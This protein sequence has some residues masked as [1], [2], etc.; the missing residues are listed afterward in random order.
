MELS[1]QERKE[2]KR[3]TD[4]ATKTRKFNTWGGIFAIVFSILFIAMGVY[5]F[6]ELLPKFNMVTTSGYDQ[7]QILTLWAYTFILLGFSTFLTGFMMLQYCKDIYFLYALLK[8]AGGI[9]D[10][11][12]AEKPREEKPEQEKITVEQQKEEAKGEPGP[13]G[14]QE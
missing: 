10:E 9:I 12:T 1:T 3:F 7:T 4:F 11:R 13:S 2:I 6:I 5:Y 8:K 14:A